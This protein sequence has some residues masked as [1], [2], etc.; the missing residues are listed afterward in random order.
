MGLSL[1]TAGVVDEGPEFDYDRTVGGQL[2]GPGTRI[3][4]A[5]GAI[6]GRE[7][8]RDHRTAIARCRICGSSASVG[9]GSRCG[10]RFVG[11]EPITRRWR[12]PL[13]EAGVED[14]A[15][16]VGDRE[17]VVA[18]RDTA[19]LLDLR[20]GALDD[21]AILVCVGIEGGWPAACG[22]LAFAGGDLVALVRDHRSDPAGAEHAPVHPTGIR[23]VGGDGV[24]SGAWPAAS[25]SGN[26]DVVEDLFEHRAVIALSTGHD[27]RQREAVPVDGVM[28]LRRQPAAGA[29]DTVPCRFNLVPRQILV[30]RS[31]PLCPGRAG[32]CSSRADAPARS[33]HPPRCPS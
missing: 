30:I 31:C 29:T 19:P 22:S 13:G 12:S 10:V 28:D 9:R 7:A 20:E 21:V 25:R 6:G 2:V 4:C 14:G 23:I 8:D 11:R 1:A 5:S 27:D 33:S 24:W 3:A 26:A 32:S 16:S 15:C 17:F 18:C